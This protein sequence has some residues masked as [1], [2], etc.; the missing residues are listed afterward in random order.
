MAV[1]FDS[2][3]N[4]LS[5]INEYEDLEIQDAIIASLQNKK[6]I[7]R[8]QLMF[9]QDLEYVIALSIQEKNELEKKE[10]K[11]EKKENKLEKKENKLEKRESLE[12]MK[13]IKEDPSENVEQLTKEELRTKRLLFFKI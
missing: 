6:N 8:Q 1:E 11:L 5:Q 3:N 13:P 10:N 4:I 9:Q 12:V 2:F 7:E